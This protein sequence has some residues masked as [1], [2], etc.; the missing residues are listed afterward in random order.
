MTTLQNP[1]PFSE[2]E[3]DFERALDYVRRIGTEEGASDTLAAVRTLLKRAGHEATPQT[4][5]YAAARLSLSL[6]SNPAAR[7]D[8]LRLCGL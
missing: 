8:F 4:V 6:R 1:R 3:P 7:A 2:A 5:F